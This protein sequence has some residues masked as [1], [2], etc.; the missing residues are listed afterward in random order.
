MKSGKHWPVQKAVITSPVLFAENYYH[1]PL[2]SLPQ[3]SYS[4]YS[5]LPHTMICPLSP[6]P[7]PPA[8][9]AEQG[10]KILT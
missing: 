3:Y 4:Y 9:E 10:E 6:P 8:A 5:V 2:V 7:P 1:S